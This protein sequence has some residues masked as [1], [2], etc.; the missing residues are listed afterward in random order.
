MLMRHG[1][2]SNILLSLLINQ[3]IR[4]TPQREGTSHFIHRLAVIRM[5]CQHIGDAL[6]LIQ[7]G[8]RHLG[9][10]L[11]SVKIDGLFKLLLR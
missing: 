10:R 5:S 3:R 2:D 6:H 11:G 1:N 9:A 8:I 4:I 7:K